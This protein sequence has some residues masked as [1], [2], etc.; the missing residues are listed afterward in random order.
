MVDGEATQK[1]DV[2]KKEIERS[3][4]E[5]ILKLR[6]GGQLEDAGQTTEHRVSIEDNHS[7]KARYTKA[8]DHLNR[9]W[10]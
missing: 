5:Y 9:I 3:I 6:H 7:M 10:R 8:Y 4:K 2:I 1:P